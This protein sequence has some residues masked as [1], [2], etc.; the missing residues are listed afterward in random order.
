MKNRNLLLMFFWFKTLL[1]EK[2]STSKE[3]MMIFNLPFASAYSHITVNVNQQEEYRMV[4][5]TNGRT[6]F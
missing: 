3:Q 1:K 6:S 4:L 2:K 5:M